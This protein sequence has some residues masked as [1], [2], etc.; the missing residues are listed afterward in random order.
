MVEPDDMWQVEERLRNKRLEIDRKY[1]YRYSR[2]IV[3][4]G[5]LLRER[6]IREAQ[7]PGLSAGKLMAIRGVA[8]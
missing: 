2:L 1:D 5:Q 7:L 6:R 4:L 3:V 8:S